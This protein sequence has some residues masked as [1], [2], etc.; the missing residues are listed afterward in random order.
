MGILLSLTALLL[1]FLGGASLVLLL[2][3]RRAG[4]GLPGIAGAAMV[5]G[6]GIVSLLPFC[7]GFFVQGVWL[8]LIVLSICA[9]LAFFTRRDWQQ[10]R[11][12]IRWRPVSWHQALLAALI[13]ASLGFLVWHSL[14]R[15][16]LEWDG[17]FNWESKARIAFLHNGT[18]PLPFYTRGFDFFH[19]RYPLLLPL[20][21]T[22]MYGF[23]SRMDQSMIKL[24]GPYFYLA[25][26]LL[27]MSAVAKE[28]NSRWPIA[29]AVMLF[30][31]T[32]QLIF[33]A[34]GASS[35]YA[36]FPLAVVY[37][38][39]AVYGV[40]Y[41]RTG[42]LDSARLVGASAMLL[43]FTKTEG[44]LLL[45]CLA[46]A[47]APAIIRR[48]DWVAGTWTLLPGFGIWFG[49]VA[50]LSLTH[51]SKATDFL[52]FT[53]AV[54]LT[55][56]DRAGQL[57]VWTLEEL[58]ASNRWSALWPLTAAAIIFL[59]LRVRSRRCFFWAA[60]VLLPLILY[61][62]VYFFSAWV[63][64]EPHVK[65]SLPRLFIHVAPAAIMIVGVA[66]GKVFNARSAAPP[67]I[68]GRNLS[69]ERIDAILEE[70]SEVLRPLGLTKKELQHLYREHVK[71]TK[72]G[73]PQQR[74][75]GSTKTIKRAGQA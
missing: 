60:S 70:A 74:Q 7:L 54:L 11:A 38:C 23:L 72:P 45:L 4:V 61:P 3:G 62:C 52:P 20:L 36:D 40:E 1:A 68:A 73:T 5:M 2:G 47:L 27:L 43:P 21:E 48:R 57:F 24:I 51:A 6:A 39:T 17:L 75:D 31:L 18:M 63:P 15:S 49:W 59:T 65:S 22:W 69:P 58:S 55:H 35:G 13:A 37:L 67:A 14:Y 32:P 25:A 46:A 12:E 29:I 50:F 64:V 28:T 9:A 10:L 66:F 42:S 56:L 71:G 53:P 8:R 26:V 30:A 19:T 44:E 34:G 16:S 41:W 33:E